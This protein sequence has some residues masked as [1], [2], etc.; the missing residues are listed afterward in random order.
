MYNFRKKCS[1]YLTLLLNSHHIIWSWSIFY[2]PLE[3]LI[4]IIEPP[5]DDRTKNNR[6]NGNG[7]NKHL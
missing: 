6:K 5:E 2:I 1:I 7:K 3:I 4:D